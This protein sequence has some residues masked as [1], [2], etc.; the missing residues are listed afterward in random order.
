MGKRRENAV[1]TGPA[2]ADNADMNKHINFEDSI[3]MLNVRIRMMRDMLRLDVDPALFLEKTLE[4]MEF[5]GKVLE[6]LMK[7]LAEHTR[8]FDRDL[9]YDNILD[10]EWQFDQLLS[11]F[12]GDSSPFFA[13]SLPETRE[14]ILRLRNAGAVR[15]KRM[16]DAAVSLEQ[17]EAEPVVSSLELNEL[18]REL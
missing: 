10:T 3:Y 13:A 17:T 5:T 1:Y 11:G 9:V 14:R 12:A 7:N 6:I 16:S 8:L 4:D 2:A 15:Q 18:L